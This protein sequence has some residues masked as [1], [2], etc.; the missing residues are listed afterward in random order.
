MFD[1]EAQIQAWSDLL[2]ARGNLTESDI[3]ELENHL[4]DEIED[5][6]A[7]GLAPDESFLI[8]VK[9]VGNVAAISHEYS[10]VNTDNLWKQLLMDPVDPAIKGQNQRDVAWVIILALLAG[11]LA[12]IPE[13]FGLKLDDPAAQLFYFKNLSLFILPFIAVFFLIKRKVGGRT[14]AVI[15]GIF[16]LAALLINFYPSFAPQSTEVLTGLHLPLFLW[17][18]VGLAYMGLGWRS[19]RERMNFIRFTGEAF[20][21]SV[22]IVC[23]VIVFSMFTLLIFTA[24]Q[25][26]ISP[27]VRDYLIVYGA[28]AVALITVYIVEAKKSVVENFAPILAKIFSPLFLATM[29]IFL[30]V[31]IIT[32][33]SPF[34]E[35]D[36][37]ITSDIML[38]LV[39]GLVL[40]V[41]SARNVH[42][43]I[44]LFDY[45]NLALIA[46]ALIIDGVALSAIIFRLSAFGITPNKLAALGE[47]LVLLGNLGG[48]VWLYIGYFRN[49]HDFIS[50]EI[51]QT[52]YLN[53]YFAWTAVVAFLFP[54]MFG[55]R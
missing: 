33:K 7:A 18:V 20:I 45:I 8:S 38:A 54:L 36:F 12:K 6:N 23:G 41:I 22:L 40:Y 26:D 31:M 52:S 14:A 21:Y 29:C 4:Q 24:I 49:K 37:L 34:I 9:R 44:N 27:F 46:V 16:A 30:A 47:N 35:R 25:I 28:C 10:K 19:S 5:L 55:F 13:F 15:L 11:T 48:L 53:V 39:L 17:L 50:L 43:K 2:R 3:R 51:W 42:E 32:G 1:L